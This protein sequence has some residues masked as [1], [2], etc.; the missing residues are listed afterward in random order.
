MIISASYKTDI[1]TFYGSWFMHR[2]RAGYCKMINPYGRQV[3]RVS[4]RQQDVDGIVFW[5]KNIGPFFKYLPEIRGMGYPFIVQHTINGYPRILE[6][7]VVD[8]NKS[9][10]NAA[11]LRKDYGARVMVWRYDTVVFSS[12]TPLSFHV[13]NFGALAETLRG[14]TDE[15][16]ISFAHFYKKTRYNLEAAAVAA[17][18]RWWDPRLEEKRQLTS[19]FVKLAQANGMHLTVCSQRENLVE[20][21]EE[22]RCVDA[23]RLE[24]VSGR[25]FSAKLKGNREECGCF[26]SRDIGDYDT[27]PHGCVYCY[28]VQ[29][30]S[31]AQDRFKRHNPD[32]EFLFEPIEQMAEVPSSDSESELDDG[33]FKLFPG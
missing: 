30:R 27:C 28:A 25:H 18:F 22:A 29:N 6:T 7:S 26:E 12:L 8:A 4:L 10:E 24:D 32:S 31:V 2:L 21:A 15:V 17:Q 3:Y 11:L 16:V 19:E 13:E 5:T 9:V 33:Q 14:V 23:R 20:G 1:P